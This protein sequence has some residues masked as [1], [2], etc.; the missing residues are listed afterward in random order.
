MP[1]RLGKLDAKAF[2]REAAREIHGYKTE[3]WMLKGAQ[4]L[5]YQ[6]RDRQ[7]P[8]RLT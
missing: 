7:R 8:R 4:I 5:N 1:P 6:P 3:P 2:A